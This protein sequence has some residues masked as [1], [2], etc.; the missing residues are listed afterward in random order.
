MDAEIRKLT[1]F[2]SSSMGLELDVARKECYREGTQNDMI[3]DLIVRGLARSFV[4]DGLDRESWGH[5]PD[6]DSYEERLQKAETPF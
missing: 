3:R 2:I 4:L 5:K 1:I 6:A